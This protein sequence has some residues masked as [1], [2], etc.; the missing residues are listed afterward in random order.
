MLRIILGII[1]GFIVWSVIWGGSDTLL[2]AISP[3]WWG[4]HLTD[5]EAAFNNKTTFRADSTILLLALAR[6]IICSLAAGYITAWI[7]GE[8]T[9]STLILGV[10]LLAFGI[11]MQAMLW[12][13]A[14]LW[15]HLPFLALLIPVTIIG[16]KL[17]KA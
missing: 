8:N 11:F 6:S 12:D 4:K 9:K 2:K 16:G 3:D 14:P 10:L 5:L 1:A 17:R 13:A 15:Y 7:A